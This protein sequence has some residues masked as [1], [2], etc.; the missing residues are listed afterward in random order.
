M[1]LEGQETV[2]YRENADL[3]QVAPKKSKLVAWF[4][5]NKVADEEYRR[6]PTAVPPE[7]LN[8]TYQNLP[9][10]A[11]W[12]EGKRA[13]PR[14]G[15][16]EIA[17][18]WKPRQKGF[19]VGRMYHVMPTEGE[20]FYLRLL[21]HNV[22]GATSFQ[23]LRTVNGQV[24][25][26]FKEACQALGLLEDDS[27]WQKCLEEARAGATP[28]QFRSL[29]AA[30]LIYNGVNDPPGLWELFK[31][32]M[33]EDFKHQ[34]GMVEFHQLHFDSAL[35]ALE[36]LLKEHNKSLADF[37]LPTPLGAPPPPLIAQE[38]G[39]YDAIEQA[40]LLQGKVHLLNPEQ[41]EAYDLI[42]QA[43]DNPGTAAN[44]VFFIDGVGGAGKTFLY[45]CVL[46]DVRANG[47]IALAVASSGIAALLLDGGRTAH[48]RFKIPVANLDAF[49]TCYVKR[50]SE[51]A[52]LIQEAAVV[53]WDE[54][55]MMSKHVFEAV[56]RTF[57]D[58]MAQVDPNLENKPFGGKVF[59]LGGDFRQILPVVR[60]GG[61]A[62]VIQA[63][64]NQ[65]ARIWPHVRVLKLHTNMRV[66]RLL[67]GTGDGAIAEA[68]RLQA[69]ADYLLRVGDGTETLHDVDGLAMIRVPPEMVCPGE[70][71]K[72]LIQEVFGELKNIS[73]PAAR[74]AF[75]THRAILTPLNQDVD[76]INKMVAEADLFPEG[77]PLAERRTYRSADSVMDAQQAAQY[78]P[79]FLNE[80]EFSGVPPHLLHLQVGCPIILLRNMTSGLANGTRLI[81]KGLM[82]NYIDA[83]VITGPA[84]G[85]RVLIPR[86]SITPSDTDTMP[87][88]LR[89]RQ[90]PVRPAFAMTINK[91][92]G[93]TFK[94]VG[95][96]LPKAVFTHGQ[97]YVAFSRV[98]DAAGVR[99][100]IP[101]GLFDDDGGL[102]TEN[103]VYT[104][105]L[106]DVPPPA[107]AA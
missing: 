65:S 23:H 87:F 75:L 30:M 68:S 98:G 5:F 78:P 103:V 76:A 14:T 92:Q 93:Q 13:N 52:K 29:F 44:N 91:S 46:H 81:V 50:G 43:I 10:L 40:E 38:L 80:L 72:D 8:T 19:S 66:L 21:L 11:V 16:T 56:D 90:F 89:R 107:A 100:L 54:A 58:I 106:M 101:G 4:E 7:C 85:Q 2:Y 15:Q 57:R 84:A 61:A 22:P 73:D 48:S 12:D 86:L 34:A 25:T 41:R 33:A 59:V 67:Q 42:K 39:R 24:Y 79:E 97:L 35:R 17:G 20:R 51:E 26:S 49:S 104:E 69:F 32:D 82:E 55:P 27:E 63:T 95:L 88:T 9:T 94:S 77:H 31:E 1:H 83:E 74:A 105:V 3:R 102:Y 96:Y 71:I 45:S 70:G 36:V 28:H 60:K 64:L 6:N 18:F 99:V 53:I 62:D 37:L 47:G